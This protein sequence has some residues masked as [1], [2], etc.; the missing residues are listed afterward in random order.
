MAIN[1]NHTF[2]ELDG[3]KCCIVEKN[4]SQERVDYLKKILE[5]NH[6]TVIVIPSPPDKKVAQKPEVVGEAPVELP[7]SPTTFTIGVTDLTF[8]PTNAIWGRLLQNEDGTIVTQKQW[9]QK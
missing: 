6:Y 2:D 1:Q 7:P 8:N 4:A 3:V 9:L 5:Y